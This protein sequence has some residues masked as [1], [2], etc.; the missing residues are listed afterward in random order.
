[1]SQLFNSFTDPIPSI[2]YDV[3]RIP[4]EQ[5]GQTYLYFHDQMGYATK[6]FALPID[7][8]LLLSLIN[9]QHS[10]RDIL[11]FSS[12]DVAED[13]ILNYVQYLDNNY[14][15]QSPHFEQ[16][17]QQVEE[18]YESA[19]VHSAIT[20]GNSYPDDPAKLKSFLDE[21]FQ[22]Y[23]KT[24][25]ADNAHAL[26]APHIDTRIGLKSYVK[27]FSA[28]K[29]LRPKTVIVLATSHYS[30]LYPKQYSESPF[31]VSDKSF[32]LPNG[33]V[34]SD[35][36]IID[37]LKRAHTMHREKTGIS[38]QDRAHR[39]E[40]SIELHLLMLNHIWSHDFNI[41][42]ILVGGLDELMYAENSFRK[43][44]LDLFSSIISEIT[45]EDTFFLISGDLSH[46]GKKF[47]DSQPA[48]SMF[49]DIEANDAQFLNAGTHSDGE[50]M[51]KLMRSN[52]DKYRICGFPPLITYLNSFHQLSGTE[53]SYDIWDE[54][55]RESAVS[56]GSILYTTK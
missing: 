8:E 28:I 37:V 40:H 39:M 19:T 18:N 1:M 11:S 51:I 43:Q 33:T 56:F 24:D 29:N 10:I 35:P 15:L 38:F 3:Q 6:D 54:A 13:D 45:T 21:A 14:V 53:L 34:H 52:Y 25:A 30:G 50:A 55:E 41:V 22:T 16:H 27:A 17:A 9:G 12:D 26:Y 44:Q 49:K 4:I 36:E 2:R 32:E 23:P 7:A 5:N 31:I 20:A 46:I 48:Q 47:G 42:P